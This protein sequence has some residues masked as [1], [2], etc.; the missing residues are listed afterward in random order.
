MNYYEQ[1]LER[2]RRN[3]DFSFKIYEGRPL[4]QKT[5]CLQMKEKV[6]HLR[7]PKNFAMLYRDR[8]QLVNYIQDTYLEVQTQERAG[9]YG[10]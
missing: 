3:F 1:Q 8:Q 7:I 10:N 6:E 2:F 4:E 9:K 5:L